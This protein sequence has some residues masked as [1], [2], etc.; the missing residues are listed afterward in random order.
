M[1]GFIF[2]LFFKAQARI[3]I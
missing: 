2:I 1:R 3:F